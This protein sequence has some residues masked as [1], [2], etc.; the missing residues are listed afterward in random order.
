MFNGGA[1]GKERLWV[2]NSF[3]LLVHFADPS[4]A[5]CHRLR[6]P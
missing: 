5:S 2:C 6:L 3:L 1:A 4:F